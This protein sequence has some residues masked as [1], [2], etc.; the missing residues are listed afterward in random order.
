MSAKFVL[1]TAGYQGEIDGK[2][3]RE[4]TVLNGDINGK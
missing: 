3:Y 2:Q 1:P 4:K